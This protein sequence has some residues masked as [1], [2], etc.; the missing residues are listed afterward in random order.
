MKNSFRFAAALAAISAVFAA[1]PN[2]LTPEEKKQM[3]FVLGQVY[4]RELRDIA[5]A[6]ETYQTILDLDPEDVT[7]AT[8]PSAP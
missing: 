1:A 8:A 5:R 2:T 3:L 6:I 7:V 4:D